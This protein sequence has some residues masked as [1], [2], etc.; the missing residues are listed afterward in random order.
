MFGGESHGELCQ[1]CYDYHATRQSRKEGFAPA[2]NIFVATALTTNEPQ[3]CVDGKN[4]FFLLLHLF[5]DTLFVSANSCGVLDGFIVAKADMRTQH[6]FLQIEESNAIPL[7]WRLEKDH[8]S[9]FGSGPR[10][11]MH[12]ARRSTCFRQGAREVSGNRMPLPAK[13]GPAVCLPSS[14]HGDEVKILLGSCMVTG[15]PTRWASE[16]GGE[17]ITTDVSSGLTEGPTFGGKKCE[18][19]SCG[20]AANIHANVLWHRAGGPQWKSNGASG[21]KTKFERSSYVNPVFLAQLK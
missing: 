1:R 15:S 5:G 20:F 14:M 13:F 17:K 9:Q 12:Q 16:R 18:K 19:C 4:S 21:N 3:H 2:R 6:I 8:Y 10:S 11:G 7:V